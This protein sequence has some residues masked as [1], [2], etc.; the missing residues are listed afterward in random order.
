MNLILKYFSFKKRGVLSD[1]YGR[2]VAFTG[3]LGF[4]ILQSIIMMQVDN[5]WVYAAWRTLQSSLGAGGEA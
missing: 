2:K 4:A 5:I 1:K 3:L